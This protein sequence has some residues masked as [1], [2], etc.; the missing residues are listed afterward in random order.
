MFASL[1]RAPGVSPIGATIARAPAP[2]VQA[3]LMIGNRDD[4]YEREADA[5]ADSVMSS[6][7]RVQRKCEC[8][9]GGASC[10]QCA[11]ER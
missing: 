2:R 7:P 11:G 1:S 9:G 3:K 4:R 10:E 6:E 5:M 8:A